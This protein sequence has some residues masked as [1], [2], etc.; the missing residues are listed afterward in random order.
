MDK[1]KELLYSAPNKLS[2][3]GQI[4][5]AL[6]IVLVAWIVLKVLRKIISRKLKIEEN[7]NQAKTRTVR[8]I[9]FNIVKAI[10]VFIAVV[11]V[12]EVFGVNTNSIIAT[13][14]IGGVALGLG[15][16][17]II[18]DFI[19]GMIIMAEDQYRVGELVKIGSLEGYVEAVSLRLTKLRD[20]NGS[21]H[22]IQNG[23]ISAVTNESRGPQRVYANIS[24]S[25]K[26]DEDQVM[27]ILNRV[28]EE[29]SRENDKVVEPFV[30]LGITSMTDLDNVY[31]LKGMVEPEYQWAIDAEIRKRALTAIKE[32]GP[33]PCSLD[34]LGEEEQGKLEGGQG[35]EV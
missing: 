28:A 27:A 15:S 10:V 4:F 31:S 18:R 11:A 8:M 34:Q 2:I 23:S 14:G 9:V 24:I 17:Y 7:F 6:V 30:N 35:D 29:E 1:F 26:A 21:L 13:A 19:S 20:F 22:I 12:L 32:S 3:P 25:K 5:F 16:Q 33:N